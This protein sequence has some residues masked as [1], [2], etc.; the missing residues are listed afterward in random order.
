MEYPRNYKIFYSKQTIEILKIDFFIRMNQ[1]NE[2][3]LYVEKLGIVQW[4]LKPNDLYDAPFV[5]NRSFLS[6][7]LIPTVND[8]SAK[9]KRLVGKNF[10]D[11]F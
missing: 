7:C 9:C 10:N 11:L 4:I 5:L 6:K 1:E 8:G 2:V 3:V